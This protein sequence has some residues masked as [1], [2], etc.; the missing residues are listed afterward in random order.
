VAVTKTMDDLKLDAMVYPTWSQ[1]PQLIGATSQQ[2]GDNSQTFSP[3]SGF[4]AMT[5]PMGYTRDN[6]LPIGMTFLGRAWSEATLIRLG[7]SYE[8]AT[9]H[10][11][12]PPTTP[13]LTSGKQ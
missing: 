5:V 8:Q 4:P 10:R 1:P 3:T 7:Y 11:R 9:H 12:P 6:T 2:A 13:P